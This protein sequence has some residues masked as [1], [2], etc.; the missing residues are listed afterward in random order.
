LRL[1]AWPCPR[2]RRTNPTKNEGGIS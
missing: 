2:G 1:L